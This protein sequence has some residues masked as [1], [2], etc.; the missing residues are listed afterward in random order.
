M[1]AKREVSSQ[2]PPGVITETETSRD[3]SSKGG[4]E[5]P[6]MRTP[7][8]NPMTLQSIYLQSLSDL[9]PLVKTGHEKLNMTH[10]SIRNP[11]LTFS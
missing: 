8:N 9:E 10:L 5:L 6:E 1:I 3:A 4:S 7:E 11:H 2:R